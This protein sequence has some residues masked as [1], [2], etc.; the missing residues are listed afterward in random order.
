MARDV[1]VA[2]TSVGL[3]H[4]GEM[5]TAVGNALVSTGR[6]VLWASEGRSA[7]TRERAAVFRD[8][9]SIEQLAVEADAIVSV[10]PPHAALDVARALPPFDGIYV[11]ANA[12]SPETARA[13]AAEVAR[14]VDGG[15]IGI[16]PSPP[17]RRSRRRSSPTP[18]R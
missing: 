7:A 16:P 8:V 5:G 10:V 18:R 12:V 11:D 2:I 15:I 6:E 13:V 1:D 4:P 17:G 14:F 3:I 9:G